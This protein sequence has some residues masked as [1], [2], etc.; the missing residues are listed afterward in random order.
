MTLRVND[1]DLDV[2]EETL[3]IMIKCLLHGLGFKIIQR[4][5]NAYYYELFLTF[6]ISIFN[7]VLFWFSEP[8]F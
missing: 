1:Y 3:S 8:N 6:I 7:Y 2:I 4:I 5:K